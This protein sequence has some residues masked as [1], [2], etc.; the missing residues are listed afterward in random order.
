MVLRLARA[1]ALAVAGRRKRRWVLAADTV[2]WA[3]GRPLGIPGGRAEA[4]GMLRSLSGRV[5]QVWTGVA[6]VPPGGRRVRLTS[7]CTRVRVARLGRSDIEA[8]LRGGEWKD[9]AG[10][11]GIQGRFAAYVR[12]LEGSYTNVVGLPLE[13]LRRLLRADGLLE[14]R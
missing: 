5:H 13:P 4:A 8:Y 1:K 6:L 2:V 14:P 7:A 11:Y 3:R 9:K 10:A 12:G